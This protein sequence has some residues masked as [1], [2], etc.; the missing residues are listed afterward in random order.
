MNATHRT[1]IGI[2]GGSGSGKSTLLRGLRSAFGEEKICIVSQDEYYRNREKQL[3][4]EA[5]FQNFDVPDALDLAGFVEDLDRLRAGE[6]V[7]RV[8][9][10]FNCE[11]EQPPSIVYKPAPVIIA[12]GLFLA[13]IPTVRELLDYSIF[14]HAREDLKLIRR[15]KRDQTERNYALEEIL[16][17]Y[18]HHVIPCYE[19]YVKR[20]YERADMVIN[21]N[22]DI[23]KGIRLLKAV[24]NDFL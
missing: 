6:T 17:R 18:E 2:T 9:Y 24:V 14:V 10:V 1:I 15:I 16:Y 23:R 3:K 21:N 12:E 11:I 5:G 22:G 4:D 8:K 19:S 13:G 7:D 20:E